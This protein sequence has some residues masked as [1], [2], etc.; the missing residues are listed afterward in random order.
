VV[1]IV[2]AIT[3][4]NTIL[5]SVLERQ[6]EYGVLRAVGTRPGQI[7][8]MVLSETSILTLAAIVLG[9]IL[10]LLV[11][12]YFSNHGIVLSNP[13]SWG[14]VE[15]N[16]MQGE[17]NARSFYLPAVTVGLTSM[18]V[19]LFPAIHAARTEPAQTMRAF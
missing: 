10:G 2:V 7:V 6:K 3:V 9:S 1:I 15:V 8:A 14:S 11:N 12:L 16:V 19:C 18:L 4:L 5:M 13:I 17:V